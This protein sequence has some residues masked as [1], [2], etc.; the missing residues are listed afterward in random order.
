[1][2]P[3]E[4]VR[5][6][7]L[8]SLTGS[9]A[10][11]ESPLKDAA[12]MAIAEINAAGGVLE[13]QI[14]PIVVDGASDPW[15]FARQA[16]RLLQQDRVVSLFGCW[17]S[18]SR[19]VLLPILERHNAL[20]WYPVQY[21]GLE[22]SPHVFYSGA[23]PNQQI[24]PA[25]GWLLRHYG[26]RFYLIGS[27]YVF[28]RTMNRVV[29]AQLNLMAGEVLGEEYVPLGATE[30]APVMQHIA[31][32]QPDVI[33]NTLNGDS[34]LAFYR[35]YVESG[36]KA[37]GIP[38]LA[39]SITESELQ[40]IAAYAEGTY[41]SWNYFQT[42]DNPENRQFVANF[43]ARYGAD[44]VTSA[45]VVSAYTQVYF[46]KQAVESAQSFDVPAVREAAYGQTVASPG[47]LL[48]LDANHHVHQFCRIG[49]A[50]TD[51]QFKVVY[52]SDVPIPPKPWMGLEDIDFPNAPLVLGLLSQVS[53]NLQANWE[54][55]QKSHELEQTIAQ[56]QQETINRQ[57]AEAELQALFQAMTDL[58]IVYDRQGHFLK[59]VSS[60]PEALYDTDINTDINRQGKTVYDVLPQDV[61]DGVHACIR[62]T[63]DTNTTNRHEYSLT[64]KGEERWFSAN[65]SPL[66]DDS[67]I[68]VARDITD[69][70]RAEDEAHHREE[71]LRQANAEANAL[72]AAMDQLI[73]VFDREGHHLKVPAVNTRI[74]FNPFEDRIGKTL[75][76]VFP[77]ETADEF[78]SYIHRSLDNM[79]TIS[80]EYS[81]LLDG[82][83]IWSDASISPIDENTVIWVTRDVTERKRSE[84]ALRRSEALNRSMLEAIPDLIT[85]VNADGVYL[86]FKPFKDLE[87]IFPAENMVGRRMHEVM[88]AEIVQQRMQAVQQVLQT[89]EVQFQ[90]YR[91]VT[92]SGDVRYQEARFSRVGD[93]EVLIMVRDITDRKQAEE[94]LRSTNAELSALFAAMDD[95]VLVRDR[96]G[97]CTKFLNAKAGSNLF[98]P[99]SQQIG[100]SLHAVFAPD[101]ADYQLRCIQEAL[102]TGQ[103]IRAEYSLI[104]NGQERWSDASISPLS[105]DT[106]LLVVRDLTQHMQVEKALAQ[107]N[108]EIG[109][110]NDR[111]KAENLRMGAEL[112][113]TRRLQRMIL[114][115]DAELKSIS[116]LDIAGFM[117]PASEVGGDYYDV[118]HQNGSITIGIGD[119]TGHGLES[120][121]LMLMVQTAVRTLLTSGETDPETFLKVLNEIIYDNVQRMDCDRSLTLSLLNYHAGTLR[122]SGQHEELI[123]VREN[124]SLERIDT[125][126]LGF[127]I[128]LVPDISTFVGYTNITLNS[129][130]VVVLY[131]DGIPEAENEAGELYGI[132]RIC[133]IATQHRHRSADEIQQAIVADVR[134]HIGNHQV[135]DDITLLVFKQK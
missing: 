39:T 3:T 59:I 65:V 21:E 28:P 132:D 55:E 22:Q 19:K 125:M 2:Y 15:E 82:K 104:I 118:L 101:V 6:G 61:A 76:E 46:W 11:S 67:V 105:E 75:H 17:T 32:A 74:Q 7:I 71:V 24:E 116:S 69:R 18:A 52:R 106:V 129:G 51:G 49:K 120:G 114:P 92:A 107:A 60:D 53:H 8:H 124:G 16:T 91:I 111:L 89:G 81:L 102:A 96:N 130:D 121:M 50:Q 12:L 66:C 77:Q 42:L 133:R 5:I 43:Q 47:G 13:R 112:D 73:F 29:E 45:P 88:P 23:C 78:L 40:E 90:E 108:A 87:S 10:L 14:E 26:K 34:N 93:E 86:D 115:K 31:T 134:R 63:L 54:L 44:R 37:M 30:F 127:P 83:E 113:I 33:L 95:I 56:L 100:T 27:D 62:R 128:G 99:V 79:D 103:T 48:R 38:I 122:L 110:L 70:K 94:E 57:Q 97:I 41:A 35:E 36:V 131:T 85:R 84:E 68:W 98:K 72:F 9:F 117:E 109:A 4:S 25:L 20:L 135:Y 123:I 126:D 1:M 80:V 119:V 64:I 58:V